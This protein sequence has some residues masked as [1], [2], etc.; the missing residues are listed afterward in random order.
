MH[1][2]QRKIQ[3]VIHINQAIYSMI[4]T[5]IHAS[6]YKYEETAYIFLKLWSGK[7]FQNNRARFN[8]IKIMIEACIYIEIVYILSSY[9]R[10]GKQREID[11]P[12][13]VWSM[14]R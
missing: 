8:P 6:V 4:G 14:P 13:L 12:D 7:Q 11:R 9:S 2:R 10:S 1:L 3:E 5:A